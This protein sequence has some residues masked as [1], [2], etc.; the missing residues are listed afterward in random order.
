MSSIAYF[1]AWVGDSTGSQ[2]VR[3][4]PR[5]EVSPHVDGDHSPQ[6]CADRP[7]G[8]PLDVGPS[9]VGGRNGARRR[10]C[11]IDARQVI[12]LGVGPITVNPTARN[13]RHRRAPDAGRS[14]S[15]SP[16]AGGRRETTKVFKWCLEAGLKLVFQMTL[17][18]IGLY[19]EPTGPY[20]PS[21]L[22]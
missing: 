7:S 18:T 11:R 1:S 17:M 8:K 3:V 14:G 16:A 12:I 15:R 13:Q 22:Y 2:H 21:V 5:F 9:T 4:K 6:H 10:Q 19:S 20:M